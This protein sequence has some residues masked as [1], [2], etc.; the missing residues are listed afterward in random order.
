MT[1]LVIILIVILIS[2]GLH[3][4]EKPNIIF[5]LADDM[6][7]SDMSWQGSSIQTPN[8][9]K[10][11]ERGMF[12]ERNYVQPQCSPSRVALLTGNYPYRYGL[13]EHVVLSQSY[14]GIPGEA[15]TI[16]EK[17]KEGGYK[18]SIIGKWHV[19]GS[20]QSQL[21][22]NQGFDHSFVCLNGAIS[23]WNYT[24]AGA[25][26]LIRN[27]EKVYAPSNLDSEES[28]NT[29]STYMWANEAVE[30]IKGHD[31][32]QSLFMYLAFNA[33]HHPLDAPQKILDKYSE[34]DIEE[35]WSGHTKGVYQS[36]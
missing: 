31:K 30:V 19:G 25:S 14:T 7:Y 15:K 5:I 10:L 28:G 22:H 23:Y 17:M 3:A 16:A 6:G 20:K 29:Y 32:S 18:T 13:H 12:L 4:Q 26:D 2:V 1:R 33:P 35:Y 36:G 11:A 21:P 24:F 27:G 8:L 9:D 34:G